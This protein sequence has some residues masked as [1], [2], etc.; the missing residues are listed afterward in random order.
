[1]ELRIK[2]LEAQNQGHGVQNQGHRGPKL[3]L[4]S[5]ESRPWKSRIK[6]IETQN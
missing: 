6:V 5:L 1:M 3:R 2:V 4:W